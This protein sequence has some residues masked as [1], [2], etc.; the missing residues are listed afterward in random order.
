MGFFQN[1]IPTSLAVFSV[2]VFDIKNPSDMK[3]Y[4][5]YE[6]LMI[7]IANNCGS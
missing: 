4:N 1:M 5:R 6:A 3:D 2:Q 7:D